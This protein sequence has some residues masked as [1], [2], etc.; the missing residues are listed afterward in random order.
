MQHRKVV[1][2]HGNKGKQ[3]SNT[4][5]ESVIAWMQRYF[6]LVGDKMPH[7]PQIH[8]LSWETQKDVYIRYAE[9]MKL[10][11]L[12]PSDIL[13]LSMFYKVWKDEFSML[14]YLR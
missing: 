13:S 1:I 11:Q 12:Q 14:L 4:K 10:Q 5:S 7:N 9:D 2:Q 8:L 3:R 6:H